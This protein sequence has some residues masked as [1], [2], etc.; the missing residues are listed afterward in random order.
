MRA[1]SLETVA[2]NEIRKRIVYADY[3]PGML[4]SENELAG[5]LG[6]SRTPI[7]SAISLLEQE[8]LVQT[9]KGRG[10]LVKEISFRQFSQLLEMLVSMQLFVLDMSKK[11]GIGFDLEKLKYYLDQQ[12]IAQE[13]GDN[14][15]YYEN[16]LHFVESLLRVQA[17]DYMLEVLDQYRA[18][19][20]CRM[21]TF[22][23]QFPEQ[24]P[25]WANIMNREIY[26]SL[27]RNDYDSAKKAVE[28]NYNIS[29]NHIMLSG[30][31]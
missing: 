19:F 12:I 25:Q 13:Q 11:K 3:M 24:K 17:N 23:K 26:E 31:F 27:L 20:I 4:L 21:V 2:Y 15:G 29:M 30:A 8:G 14:I 6:M 1:I 18:K 9:F 16:S 10:V 28:E 22:R 5:E 7:R